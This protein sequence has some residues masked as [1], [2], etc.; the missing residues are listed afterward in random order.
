MTAAVSV[1]PPDVRLMNGAAALSALLAGV[2]LLA[3]ALAWL[4]RSSAFPLRAID[5]EGDVERSSVATLRANVMPR[6]S[7][8]FFSV[9][10]ERVRAAFEAVPWV[11]SA[12][13]R[14]VWP[15]RLVV[16]LEEH[17]PV[18]L[19]RGRR[20]EGD[21]MVNRFGEVFEANLGDVEDIALPLLEGPPDS[22]GQMLAQLR[23]LQPLL[24]WQQH[25]VERLHLSAQGSWQVTLDGEVVIELG[26]G[27]EDEVVA[28]VDRFAR[29]LAQVTAHFGAPLLS[30]DLRHTDSYAVRLRNVTTAPASTAL[31][32]HTAPP[33]RP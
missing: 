11:R 32:A 17:Q 28:R 10:V 16:R 1:L 4:G 26:R 15:D 9:D 6:L 25:Q 13:V 7:G 3:S 8:N 30:A 5:L 33:R 27:G 20:Q 22:A 19:W 2:L 23:R 31:P 12:S 14:R 24:A 29:T 21:R 18:A